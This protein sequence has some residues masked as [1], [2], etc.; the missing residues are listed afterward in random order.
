MLPIR[1]FAKQVSTI[2]WSQKSPLLFYSN[3]GLIL[4]SAASSKKI[5]NPWAPL[6]TYIRFFF[7]GG[8]GSSNN[9]YPGVCICKRLL[10]YHIYAGGM[11]NVENRLICFNPFHFFFFFSF[12][13]LSFVFFFIKLPL[14]FREYIG[15]APNVRKKTLDRGHV[16][17]HT[18]YLGCV[19]RIHATDMLCILLSNLHRT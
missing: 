17:Q 7:L 8:G 6:C 15:C 14:K 3:C 5:G 19:L 10:I 12:S 2:L 18:N 1:F 9:N 13:N 16:R 11:P 4:L